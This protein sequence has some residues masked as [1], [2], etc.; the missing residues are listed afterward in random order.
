MLTN[1]IQAFLMTPALVTPAIPSPYIS[2]FSIRQV[3]GT[4]LHHFHLAKRS[5]YRPLDTS[6]K[7][8]QLAR[9]HL[10]GGLEAAVAVHGH[11][12]WLRVME[13]DAELREEATLA[14]CDSVGVW[15]APTHPTG[16][17]AIA[18]FACFVLANRITGHCHA[19]DTST[20]TLADLAAVS[21][22]RHTLPGSDVQP[23]RLTFD[24]AGAVEY[25]VCAKLGW[26][27]QRLFQHSEDDDR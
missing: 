3:E 23:S 12:L 20:F 11:T 1:E 6:C 18:H 14:G 7:I 19:S 17:A 22:G 10:P 27:F 25:R 26:R 5:P 8:Y 16:W 15:R 13:D 21:L 9:L 2:T 24:S 4:L